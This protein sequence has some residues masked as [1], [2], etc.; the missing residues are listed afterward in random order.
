MK[1][2]TIPKVVE[3]K[4]IEHSI[5]TGTKY[6]FYRTS[7]IN[8]FAD[9]YGNDGDKFHIHNHRD[10]VSVLFT[11]EELEAFLPND[12]VHDFLNYLK[13]KDKNRL[14]FLKKNLKKQPKQHKSC[15]KVYNIQEIWQEEIEYLETHFVRF[16]KIKFVDTKN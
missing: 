10:G 4:A 8:T 13:E 5:F 15:G 1:I 2:D 16:I 11:I 3:E 9:P 12:T 7:G 6:A 14:D